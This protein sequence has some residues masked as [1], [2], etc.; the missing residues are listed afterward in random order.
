MKTKNPIVAAVLNFFFM[1][2]GYIYSGTKVM[3]GVGFTLGAIALTY[4][5]LGIQEIDTALWGKMFAAVL[6]INTCFA[7]D[8]YRE[9][10]A[11]KK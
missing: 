1:G 4:V 10:K 8:V 2:L 3:L 7:V 5:E 11:L 6:L 9:T